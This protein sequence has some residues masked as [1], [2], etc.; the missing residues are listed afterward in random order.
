MM[1]LD[2]VFYPIYVVVFEHDMSEFYAEVLGLIE[3][4]TFC[5]KTISPNTWEVLKLIHKSFDTSG[6]D[7]LDEMLPCFEN[8]IHYGASDLPSR[9]D[10]LATLYDIFDRIISDTSSRLGANDRVVACIIAKRLMTA[11]RGT[12]DQMVPQFLR[13]AIGRL[14]TDRE[15]LKNS[16]YC[17]NLLEVVIAAVY[18]NASMTLSFL[19]SQS[20]TQQFFSLWFDKMDKFT[21]VEDKQLAV[22]GLLAIVTLSEHEIPETLKSTLPQLTNGCIQVL[23]SL[24]S[25]IE[26]KEALTKSFPGDDDLYED[27]YGDD[28]EWGEDDEGESSA[29]DQEYLDFLAEE[30]AK[31]QNPSSYGRYDYDEEELDEDVFTET[32]LDNVNTFV[33]FKDTF[34]ALSQS[35]PQRYQY[36]TGAFGEGEKKIVEQMIELANSAQ[37]QAS[38]Q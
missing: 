17:V 21:R 1:K 12:I 25:A 32:P 35:D 31:L 14:V 2:E 4:A 38:Q 37:Q 10:M 13:V 15:L 8:Y 22:L 28:D 16:S 6:T 33:V 29:A 26:K 24:P 20:F 3:N 30:S 36:I 34:V 5:V 11:L 9:T 23:G 18:Y 27:F 7:F 19:E